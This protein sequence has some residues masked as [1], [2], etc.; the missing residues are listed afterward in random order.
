MI[1]KSYLN[2]L[3][4]HYPQRQ[5]FALLLY[6]FFSQ[7]NAGY[8]EG[9]ALGGKASPL[10]KAGYQGALAKSTINLTFVLLGI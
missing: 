4:G 7:F 2:F 3:S 9:M 1:P 10:P 6:I 5:L 8:L